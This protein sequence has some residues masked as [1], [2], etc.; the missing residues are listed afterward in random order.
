MEDLFSGHIDLFIASPNGQ[1]SS[2]DRFI[3]NPRYRDN[4]DVLAMYHF[5]GNLVGVSLRTKQQLGFDLSSQVW[6]TIVCE[7]V[8]DEDLEAVDSGYMEMV[9][10]VETASEELKECFASVFDLVMMV[11]DSAGNEVEL[12]PGGEGI[13]VTWENHLEFAKLAREMR[14]NEAKPA[15]E[16][17]AEGVWEIVPKK[18]L[19]LF[20]WEQLERNVKGEPEVETGKRSHV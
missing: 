4:S 8:T 14:V 9:K 17:I 5:V 16:A 6:K 1:Q 7:E 20:T 19:T 3:P 13:A 15:A 2:E 10:E 18:V 12:V 11:N